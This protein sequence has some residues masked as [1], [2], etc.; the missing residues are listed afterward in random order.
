LARAAA[1]S[2]RKRPGA[3]LLG[4]FAAGILAFGAVGQARAEE[5]ASA[6]VAA[7]ESSSGSPAA[8]EVFVAGEALTLDV[9]LDTSAFLAGGYPIDSAGYAEFPV[10]GKI[11]VAGRSRE[12]LEAYLGQKFANYLKDTHIKA[13][14]AIRLT[15]IGYWVR[16]GMYY[17]NPNSTVWDAVYI[18][19]GIAGERT[20]DK[21][22]VMRGS[23]VTTIA[24]LDEYS[25]G[26][27]LKQSGIRSG[28]IIVVPVPRDNVG[29]WYWFRETITL[30]AQI[31]AVLTSAMSAYIIYLNLENQ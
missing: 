22:D 7:S 2:S 31:A 10:V 3:V 20:L 13:V 21:I 9:A 14:P 19:G 6:A 25:K 26:A 18:S 11:F 30:T 16:Q 12:D 1:D 5:A 28:D 17:V 23:S 27:T 8:E 29:F 4:L 24:F 15:L